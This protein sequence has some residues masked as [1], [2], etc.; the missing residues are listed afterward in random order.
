MSAPQI[1]HATTEPTGAPNDL[2]WRP[3]LAA[4]VAA[5]AGAIV[6]AGLSSPTAGPAADMGEHLAG[7]DLAQLDANRGALE[8][9]GLAAG[10]TIYVRDYAAIDGDA[11]LFNGARIPLGAQPAQLTV[12]PG[13]LTLAAVTGSTG[14]VTVEIGDSAGVY[15]LCLRD[16]DPIRTRAR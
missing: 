5:L 10:S 16:G 12:S 6:W 1:E 9:A 4:T 7:A 13:R 15:Q 14:C 11:V 3:V 8:A 2:P